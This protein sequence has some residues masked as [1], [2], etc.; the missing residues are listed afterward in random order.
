MK[1]RKTNTTAILLPC[2]LVPS[3]PTKRPA[4]FASDQQKKHGVCALPEN[5]DSRLMHLMR[6]QCLLLPATA[7]LLLRRPDGKIK[8]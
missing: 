8:L 7:G 1:E 5:H 2:G 4:P 3:T 6:G